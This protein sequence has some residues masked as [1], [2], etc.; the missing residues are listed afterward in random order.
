MYWLAH[1]CNVL[2]FWLDFPLILWFCNLRSSETTCSKCVEHFNAVWNHL[3]ITN[4]WRYLSLVLENL[5]LSWTA[6]QHGWYASA[7]DLNKSTEWLRR[8]TNCSKWTS[9]VFYGTWFVPVRQLW[10]KKG[11]GHSRVMW[12]LWRYMKI[13]HPPISWSSY[14]KKASSTNNSIWA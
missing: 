1:T 2:L 3:M 11:Q 13:C 6:T 5:K 9:Q 7:P 12:P 8:L 14:Q 10:W 4:I